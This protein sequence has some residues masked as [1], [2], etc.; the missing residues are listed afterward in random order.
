MIGR[1]VEP[2]QSRR[3]LI[4]RR[5]DEVEQKMEQARL[6][7][8]RQT[9]SA[10]LA[11]QQAEIERTQ[12]MAALRRNEALGLK[13]RAGIAGVLQQVPV[14]VGQRISPGTNLARVADPARLKAQ[15]QIAETQVKDITIGQKAEIDTRTGIVRGH[16][17]RTD[18]A[19]K[20]GTVTVDV[21]YGGMFYVIAEAAPRR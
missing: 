17:A 16:V 14:D 7:N 4:Q 18:P 2:Y 5:L 3:S 20:N 8:S 10:R 21:A 9:V 6:A 11:V 19:A 12:T 15:L 1:F 13:I